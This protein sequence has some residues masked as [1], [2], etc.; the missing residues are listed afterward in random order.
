MEEPPINVEDSSFVEIKFGAETAKNS[1]MQKI[2]DEK[3]VQFLCTTYGD[4]YL[5][6]MGHDPL[7]KANG[8]QSD[9]IATRG[10]MRLHYD[11]QE[12]QIAYEEDVTKELKKSILA[13]LR[14]LQA[15]IKKSHQDTSLT[16]THT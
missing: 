5:S 15:Q 10:W 8:I 9:D 16:N 14:G 3:P 13:A 12:L 1:V 4:L 11:F 6:D 7:R 2:L